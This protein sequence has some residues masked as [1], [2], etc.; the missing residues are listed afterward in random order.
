[1]ENTQENHLRVITE[2]LA[3]INHR[4]DKF[5]DRIGALEKN[6]RP[7]IELE[8][9]SP[10]HPREY[11]QHDPSLES[12]DL[13]GIVRCILT[14]NIVQEDW[15]RTNILQTFVKLGDKVCKIIVDSGSCVNAISSS[16]VKALG[17]TSVPHP[18]PYKV[19]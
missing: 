12:E 6:I 2:Q 5:E 3:R 14:Q 4:L 11:P 17:L 13:L 8:S 18:N 16:T 19:S 15:H 1:M 9:E 7:S 10:P